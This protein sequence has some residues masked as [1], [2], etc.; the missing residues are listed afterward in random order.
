MDVRR[1]IAAV[2]VA[3]LSLSA[4]AA[5]AQVRVSMTADRTSLG[6]GE[7]L[8]VQITV[9]SEGGGSP[10]IELPGFAGFQV[11]SQQ[12]QRPM[13]F[14]FSF[15]SRAVVRS[16]T[17]YTFGLQPVSVGRLTIDPVRVTVD[18]QVFTSRALEI[19]VV[20][21]T[22]APQAAQPG[23]TGS[24]SNAADA[25]AVDGVAFLRTVVD[26]PE[27]YV[28]EQVTVTIYLYVRQQ[29][30]S[31]P[32]IT[33]EASTEGFWT[34]DLLSPDH[35]LQPQRQV[36]G[37]AV[38]AVYVLRR[39]AAFA[40]RSGDLA[41]GP[42]SLR[43][44][45]SSPFDMFAPTRPGMLERTGVAVPVRVR[46]LP[47]EGKPEGDVAVGRFEL[48]AA[49]DRDQIA[50]GDAVTLKATVRGQGNLGG[51]RLATPTIDGVEVLQPETKDLVESPQDLV[52]STRS[53]AW[54]LVPKK[55]G[56]HTLPPL[57]LH[58]FDPV[59]GRYQTLTSAPLTLVA[60]GQA[61]GVP[62]E[63]APAASDAEPVT[64]TARAESVEWPPIRAR[65]A[66]RRTQARL[67][68]S[69]LY[70]GALAL[71]PFAW[72]C[73]LSVTWARRRAASRAAQPQAIATRE[74][75]R[76]LG[77]AEDAAQRGE[78]LAFH[79]EAAAALIG[80]LRARVGA[81]VAGLTR[82]EL[83]AELVRRGTGGELADAVVTQLDRWDFARF[84]SAGTVQLAEEAARLR[85]LFRRIEALDLATQEAA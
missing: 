79:A 76:H 8:V 67:V 36:V 70:A 15:G 58:T 75:R 33:Q 34:H 54:L 5:Q 39:F 59:S 13:Q 25:A 6:L 9:Q 62:S 26:R 10:D 19:T 65:S 11:V 40:L 61:V 68:D 85:E 51:V 63:P 56:V 47:E 57:V 83:R 18:G 22:G 20:G 41:I 48:T 66:L 77:N 2:L 78:A 52:T 80:A 4:G 73:L 24:P 74:A 55:A 60:A 64:P 7:Q 69:A 16:S 82:P 49:L 29:L 71:P 50:T 72:L 21:G 43:I 31:A 53:Y 37:D 35:N 1:I 3:A 44:D 23:A 30:R 14:S 84:G 46:P 32:G 28:G 12:I 42:M 17:N 81:E 38:Y 27:P 45:T